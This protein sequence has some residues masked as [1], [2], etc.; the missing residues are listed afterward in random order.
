[1]LRHT[2]WP[3]LFYSRFQ[4]KQLPIVGRFCYCIF[5]D[6]SRYHRSELS[7]VRY[8]PS[9]IS[10]S[11]LLSIGALSNNQT[12]RTPWFHTSPFT[13]LIAMATKG[14]RS[15]KVPNKFKESLVQPKSA[16][17][18]EKPA[19]TSKY[20]VFTC[21]HSD[22]GR[23]STAWYLQRMPGWQGCKLDAYK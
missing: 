4:L 5:F 8:V 2:H 20:D 11:Y 12:F 9:T 22:K 3:R 14:K 16:S 19:G 6:D 10:I 1:M 17:A 13:C 15:R 7:T 21:M 23:I 18:K